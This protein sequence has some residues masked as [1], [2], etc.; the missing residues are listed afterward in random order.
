MSKVNQVTRKLHTLLL[1]DD[2]LVS[3][4]VLATLLTMSGLSVHTAEDGAS[5]VEL[6]HRGECHPEL[7]LMDAQMPGLEGV[8]LI[9]E[10]RRESRAPI[11]TM[12]ASCPDSRILEQT[13]GFLLKPFSPDDLQNLLAAKA[14]ADEDAE[15]AVAARSADE[16]RKEIGPET[17]LSHAGDEILNL[18]TLAQ[19][20]HLMSEA[21]I[22]EI[23][24]ALIAD[25]NLRSDALEAAIND[26]DMVQVRRI[27]HAIKG[28]SDIAGASQAARLGALIEEGVLE[29]GGGFGSDFRAGSN[30]LDIKARILRDLRSA[31]ANLQRM[32][33]QGLPA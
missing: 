17:G 19:L 21:A 29:P 1:I 33:E 5:A 14:Q 8:P 31:A 15:V 26:G 13:D 30:H 3:R 27:G 18:K 2:D 7:I 23:F 22:R 32:L 16:T 11:F 28:G 24:A 10:L 25:L 20:R 9:E 12:S 4:E 6:L